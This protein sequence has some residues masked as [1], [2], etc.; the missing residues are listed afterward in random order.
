MKCSECKFREYDYDL[1]GFICHNEYAPRYN[2]LSGM[3]GESCTFGKSVNSET[4]TNVFTN[5]QIGEPTAIAAA[6]AK[7]VNKPISEISVSGIRNAAYSTLVSIK[8]AV[9]AFEK[10]TSTNSWKNQIVIQNLYHVRE[11][12]FKL[13]ESIYNISDDNTKI[14]KLIVLVNQSLE[15]NSEKDTLPASLHEDLSKLSD[16]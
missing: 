4:P 13:L 15:D 16:V 14:S 5:L 2:L 6:T 1:S 12:M 8:N 7:F 9:D 3:E 11:Q 10:I